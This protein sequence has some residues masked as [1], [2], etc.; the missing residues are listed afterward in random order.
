[1]LKKEGTKGIFVIVKTLVGSVAHSW[2]NDKGRRLSDYILYAAKE[3]MQIEL[4]K[5]YP[6]ICRV[7]ADDLSL[8]DMERY[9]KDPIQVPPSLNNLMKMEFFDVE[10][11][12]HHPAK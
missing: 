1:M 11:Y 9:R 4:E 12:T 8:R 2:S 3:Q 10:N 6:Y 7:L 5:I